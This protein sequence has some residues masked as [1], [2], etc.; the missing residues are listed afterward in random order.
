[1]IRK[2]S[3]KATVW[4]A[5]G[6]AAAS[7]GDGGQAA[8]QEFVPTSGTNFWND[9]NNWGPAPPQPFPNGP[10]ALATLPAPTGA[11]TIDLGQPI[12]VDT[13]TVNK[14]I[15]LTDTYNTTILGSA[16]NTLKFTGTALF[17]NSLSAEGTGVTIADAPVVFDSPFT[18]SQ[19]DD[20]ELRFLQPL[21]G[22]GNLV[23]GRGTSGTGAVI[24]NAANTYQGSTTFGGGGAANYLTVRLNN[25]T[26]IPGGLDVAGGTSNIALNDAAVLELGASDFQRGIGAGPDQIQFNGVGTNGFVARGANRVVNIGGA[27]APIVWGDA[28]ATFGELTFGSTTATHTVIFENPLNIGA[29]NRTIRTY[30]GPA[31]IETRFTQ[32]ISSNS[33]ATLTKQGPGA[34]ALA[35]KNTYTGNTIVN[36]GALVLEHPEALPATTNVTLRAGGLLGLAI[37]DYNGTLGTGPGQLQFTTGNGGFAAFGGNFSVTLNGGAGVA[38]GAGNF[39]ANNFVLSD[40]NATGTITFTN[41]IDLGATT[42]VL[43]IRNGSADLD[44]RVTGV[45]SGTGSLN[46]TQAGNV[47]L[48]AANTYTGAT[49]INNGVVIL[50]NANSIPGGVTGGNLGNIQIANTNGSIGLGATDFTSGLGTGPGQINLNG[51][52][53]DTGVPFNAGFAAYGGNRVVNLGGAAAPVTWNSGNFVGGNLLLGAVG[54]D[55]T[56]DF[57]NP[58][59]LNGAPR[60]IVGRDGTAAIDAIISGVISGAAASLQKNNNGAIALTAAN[61]YD[62]GTI[63]DQGLLL[64]NNTT[65]SAVGTGDVSILDAG[66]LGGTGFVGTA[67]DASNVAV[68]LGGRINPGVE[69][70]QLTVSGN[71]TFDAGSFLDVDL[72]GAGFDKLAITGGATLDGTLNVVVPDG[73][74]AT[75]GSTYQILTSTSGVTGQFAGLTWNGA[76]SWTAQYDANSVTLVAGATAGFAADFDLDGDVDSDDLGRWKTNF[77]LATGGTKEL[78]D[79]TGDGVVDGA[80]FLAWQQ[81]FGSGVTPPAVATAVAVP[82][83]ATWGLSLLA[84]FGGKLLRRKSRKNHSL[85]GTDERLPSA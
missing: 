73:F 65:G 49:L 70:G 82:E 39:A 50:T 47:E 80:D 58:I 61:T 11:L 27:G 25:A 13:L 68:Q 26:S 43:A 31:S 7:L 83:P 16:T 22:T 52:N 32:P 20:G 85:V 17:S 79:A 37:G 19:F 34:L 46:K 78:G 9:N 71:V 6:I 30:E 69:I 45:I 59:D 64:A 1:M 44:A 67:G 51:A 38:W 81:Q 14:G 40:D 18:V 24:L 74:V 72:D 57:Q 3:T 48:A 76:N 4:G 2:L 15:A 41:P 53:V 28:G 8:G 5:V 12:E 60:I 42:R 66:V 84:L 62:G 77:G 54:S 10:G 75:P 63:I 29:A 33:A 23:V 35:A 56:V 21:S 36:N 55:G